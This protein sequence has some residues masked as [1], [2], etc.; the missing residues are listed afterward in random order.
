[1]P[2]LPELD[3]VCHG[4]VRLAAL[5]LLSGVKEAEFTWLRNKIGASDGN[6]SIHL[7]KLENAKY[8]KVEKQ[9]VGK[10]PQTLYRL[11]KKGREAFLEY[12]CNLKALL[13]KKF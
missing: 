3:E 11:T 5:S 10:K 4:Q 12:V 6:L 9:F 1:V 7:S 8:I 2:D 13:G